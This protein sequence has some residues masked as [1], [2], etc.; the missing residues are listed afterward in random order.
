MN[1]LK[2][3]QVDTIIKNIGLESGRRGLENGKRASKRN[4]THTNRFTKTT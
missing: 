4:N 3:K 1:G 2:D